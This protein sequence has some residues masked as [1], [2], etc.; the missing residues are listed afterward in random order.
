MKSIS[1]PLLTSGVKEEADR[2]RGTVS[3]LAPEARFSATFSYRVDRLWA[4]PLIKLP[5]LRGVS[6]SRAG[7]ICLGLAKSRQS[8]R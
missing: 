7:T 1:C 8:D 6:D 2:A 4:V 5:T 3:N